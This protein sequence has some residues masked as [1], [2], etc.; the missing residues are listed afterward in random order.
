MVSHLGST[1]GPRFSITG[2]R[3]DP[4]NDHPLSL[5]AIIASFI[6]L[7]ALILILTERMDRTIVALAGAAL[8]IAVGM[9]FGFYSEHAA[10][11]AVDFETLGLLFGMMTLVALLSPTGVFEYMATRA[12]QMS[13]G[14]PVRLLV[15]LG[16]VT[17]VL[18]MFLDNVTTVVL[19]APV[20]VLVT[21][22]LGISPVPFLL[23]EAVLSNTGGVA[24]LIGDPPN[25]LIGSAANLTFNDFLVHSLP[26]V[27]VAWLAALVTLLWLFRDRLSRAPADPE[28]L[29]RLDPE[30]ALNDLETAKKV[31]VVLL[32]T[33]VLFFL[34]GILGLTSSFIALSMGAAALVWL[35]PSV[36]EAMDRI[37]WPVLLFF[38]GLFV[39]VGG[40]EESGA[41][42]LVEQAILAISSAHGPV[43]TA[44]AIIW[45]AALASALVDNIPIT[46]ALIPVIQFLESRGVNSFPLWWA[47]A[48]GAGFG[49]NGTIIG[50][51][52]NIIVVQVS[53]R[54]NEPIRSGVWHRR[55]FPV[56]IVTCLIGSLAFALA[57]PL[58]TR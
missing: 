54:T 5:P 21:E 53:Q 48:F 25:V 6:F 22:I 23:S 15:L 32:A 28:V 13:M 19:I 9:L 44:I 41:L 26:V 18:S 55:G 33:M 35:R 56:M 58:F 24:T 4:R 11:E 17:T 8:M 36:E 40:L 38:A 31:G 16:V 14:N 3:T 27:V 7:I 50:S 20:T 10:I 45:I 49:G 1:S 51:T 30:G 37:E 29:D 43:V 46:V 57:F 34:Q 2:P 52:A 42:R 47:L 39:M 12:A